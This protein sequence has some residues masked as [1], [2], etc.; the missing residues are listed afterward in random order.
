MAGESHAVGEGFIALRGAAP[1]IASLWPYE[2]SRSG[3]M[4]PNIE[5]RRLG[6]TAVLA[7]LTWGLLRGIVQDRLFK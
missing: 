5:T 1:R 2:V 6:E 7:H 4:L 3:R